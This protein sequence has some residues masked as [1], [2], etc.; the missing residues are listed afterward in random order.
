MNYTY[1]DIHSHLNLPEF[2]A[3]RADVI[4]KLKTSNIATI[5]VGVDFESSKKAILLA[6][7]N[8]NLYACV[9]LHPAD[10]VKEEFV[11]EE[12]KKLA[13][14]K[15]VVAI[16]ETGLDYFRLPE[17]KNE[18]ENIVNK[19]K[20]IFKKHIEL[21]ITIAKPLM[22]HARPSKG[23]MDAYMDVLDILEAYKLTPKDKQLVVNF[24]FFVGNIDVA[25]RVVE[26]GHTVSFDGPITF[27]TEYDEV[28]KYLPLENIMAETDAPFAAPVPY[29]GKRCEPSYVVEVYKKIAEIKGLDPEIVR[30][31]I[32]QT[33]RRVFSVV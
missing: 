21:A 15:K 20:E 8:E 28:I 13:E 19:Q 22:I 18:S 30:L 24:H 10:N 4:E 25:K 2:D 9:G 5:T 17:N 29:R 14:H 27:T 16:G 6:D 11:L 31:Q 1:I 26:S 33:A 23:S 32:N 7:Q 3:D 12:Y